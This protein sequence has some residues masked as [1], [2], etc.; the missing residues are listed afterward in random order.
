ML[1]SIVISMVPG[2]VSSY[3]HSLCSV[4]SMISVSP[5]LFTEELFLLNFFFV[6]TPNVINQTSHEGY[7]RDEGLNTTFDSSFCVINANV[8][9]EAFYSIFD[10]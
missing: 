2:T 4:I 8:P 7:Q 5:H 10:G 6:D 1:T 9:G 3:Q